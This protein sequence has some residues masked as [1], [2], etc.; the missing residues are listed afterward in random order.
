MSELNILYPKPVVVML[1]LRQVSI[2]PVQLRHF[3]AFGK[4]AGGL[5]TVVGA[6]SPSAVYAYAQ[7]S[8]AL[9]DLLGTCT[10]LSAWRIRRLPTASALELMIKVVEINNGFFDQALVKA[11]SQLAGVLSPKA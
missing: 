7:S 4:A 5:I 10:N 9:R 11:A 1:G 8:A 3:E 2:R 6:Q